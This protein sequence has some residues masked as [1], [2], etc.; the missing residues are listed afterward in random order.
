MEVYLNLWKEEKAVL[1]KGKLKLGYEESEAEL[2]RKAYLAQIENESPVKIRT[3]T[4]TDDSERPKFINS[5]GPK[6]NGLFQ[7]ETPSTENGVTEKRT[8]VNSKK[9][10]I[11]PEVI[12][13]GNGLVTLTGWE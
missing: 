6:N 9:K 10:D 2:Q 5:K 13:K 8:F 3:T 7:N 11:Q 1:F 4:K 12:M